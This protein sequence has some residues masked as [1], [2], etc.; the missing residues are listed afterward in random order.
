MQ[1]PTENAQILKHCWAVPDKTKGSITM[2]FCFFAV[3]SA[4]HL[5]RLVVSILPPPCS[6]PQR[7]RLAL[8]SGTRPIQ[9]QSRPSTF[10]VLSPYPSIHGRAYRTY[11]F[12][13][14]RP[15]CLPDCSYVR[16]AGRWHVGSST[17]LH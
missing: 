7:Q 16:T 8:R 4:Y 17:S 12:I 5:L 6:I 10:P 15:A 3:S 1:C 13:C 11:V 9:A 14:V 2:W